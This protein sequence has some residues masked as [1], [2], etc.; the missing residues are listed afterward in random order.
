[1]FLTGMLPTKPQNNQKN[2][3]LA[4]ISNVRAEFQSLTLSQEHNYVNVEKTYASLS[5][6]R[7]Y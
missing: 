4:K 1:M 5:N 2:K 7:I 3:I 6:I